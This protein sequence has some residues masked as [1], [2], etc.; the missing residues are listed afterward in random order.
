[1]TGRTPAELVEVIHRSIFH[2]RTDPAYEAALEL[3]AYLGEPCT[4]CDGLGHNTAWPHTTCPVCN[5]SR[6][7]A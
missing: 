4:N 1:M 3:A 5:G 2:D 7:A 6:V